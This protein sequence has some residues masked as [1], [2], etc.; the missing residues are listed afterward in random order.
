MNLH[1][2]HGERATFGFLNEDFWKMDTK[3]LE[4]LLLMHDL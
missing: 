4:I 3:P 1:K 2:D